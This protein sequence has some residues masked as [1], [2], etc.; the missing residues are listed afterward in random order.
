MLDSPQIHIEEHGENALTYQGE[1]KVYGICWNVE[2]IEE[3]V[4]LCIKWR[5][6]VANSSSSAIFIRKI[7]MLDQNELEGKSISFG[8]PTKIEDLRFYSNGW[9]SWSTTG[10][11]RPGSRMRRSN[12]GFLQNPMVVNPDT[13]AFRQR[14]LFSSDFFS[15]VVDKGSNSGFVL[16][17]L[18]QR[19]HFGSIS[20]DFRETARLQVWANGDDA[21]LDPGQ[22]IST[23]WAALF[24]FDLD[25]QDPFENY[26]NE[27]ALE[28]QI[29]GGMVLVVLLLPGHI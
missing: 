13:P 18:S 26:L 28:H 5:I 20:A 10:A 22:S 7:V 2:F 6:E 25:S 23:D 3:N 21:R 17:F 11:F 14:G 1:D 8:S 19:Q 9:Q 15:L 29:S 27:V 16:G 4:P 24:P 12:L